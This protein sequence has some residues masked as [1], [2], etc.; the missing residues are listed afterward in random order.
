MNPQDFLELERTVQQQINTRTVFD[1]A[2]RR[3][4]LTSNP[5]E[6]QELLERELGLA[7]PAGVTIQV[8]QGIP[9]TVN[10]VLPIHPQPGEPTATELSDTDLV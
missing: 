10:L 8:H 4:L 2:F 3:K 7:L 9:F 6:V 5:K 1:E